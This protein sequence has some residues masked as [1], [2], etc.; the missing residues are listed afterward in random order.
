MPTTYKA[1]IR[2]KFRPG[3]VACMAPRNIFLDNQDWM[4]AAAAAFGFPDH[5]N[6][7]KVF[8]KL[9]DDMP[10]DGPWSDADL[11]T[12]QAWMDGGFLTG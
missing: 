6:A 3:D 1:D 7:R 2:P 8:A 10:P 4:C 11:A 9:N 12:Y 5:G